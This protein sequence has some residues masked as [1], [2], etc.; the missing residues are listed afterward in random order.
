M[1]NCFRHIMSNRR[2]LVRRFPTAG[3][4]IALASSVAIA[5]LP[6][7][8]AQALFRS[9]PRG[10]DYEICANRL[11]SAGISPEEAADSCAAALHP[12]D[13]SSCVLS[14]DSGTPVAAVDALTGC[15]RVRRPLDLAECVVD[16]DS[17]TQSVASIESLDYCRR[18]LLPLE[19]SSCVVGLRREID[20]E[21]IAAMDVCI[22]ADDRAIQYA[23]SV[24]LETNPSLRLTP[25]EVR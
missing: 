10:N 8:P 11:L 14:I 5:G 7:S 16:V 17:D 12:Q 24:L 6:I 23:P 25:L 19:F 3:A 2:L 4:A 1:L 15:K 20:L 22:D 13:L 21:A 18:S 9:S